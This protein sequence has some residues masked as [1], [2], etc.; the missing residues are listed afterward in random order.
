MKNILDLP[1]QHKIICSVNA[2]LQQTMTFTCQA[3]EQQM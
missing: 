2:K 1:S 3:K